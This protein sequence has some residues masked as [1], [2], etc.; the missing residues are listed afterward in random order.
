[1]SGPS[2]CQVSEWHGGRISVTSRSEHRIWIQTD[3]GS[4]PSSATCFRTA[5][6]LIRAVIHATKDNTVCHEDNGHGCCTGNYLPTRGPV[7]I[8]LLLSPLCLTEFYSPR[9]SLMLFL[10]GREILS[11]ST[12]SMPFVFIAHQ[13]Q[14]RPVLAQQAHY[15]E[16]CELKLQKQAGHRA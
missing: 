13:T 16:G 15:A 11:P 7:D 10:Q 1:M 12:A 14:Q 2:C 8:L 6:C 5:C 3:P 4:H 9:S